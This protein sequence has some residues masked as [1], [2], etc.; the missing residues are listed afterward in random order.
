MM[1]AISLVH[2]VERPRHPS[3]PALHG[4]EFDFRKSLEHAGTAETRDWLDSGRERMRYVVDDRAAFLACDARIA[5]GRDVEG[6]RQIA[7]VDR[8]PHRIVGGQIVVGIARVVAA[9]YRLAWE[10]QE[11]KAHFRDALDFLDR[12]RHVGGHNS[13]IG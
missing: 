6:D 4:G 11:S 8:S 12:E 13:Q 7:I 3:D 5:S 10:S 1:F 2:R 9:E